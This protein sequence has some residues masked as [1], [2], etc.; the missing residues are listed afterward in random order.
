MKIL[1]TVVIISTALFPALESRHVKCDR[2]GG[3]CIDGGEETIKNMISSWDVRRRILQAA[4]YISYDA[5]NHNIPAKQ[6][7]ISYDALKHNV[8]AKQ[9]GQK[10][11]PDNQYRR[12]CLL[13]TL[14]LRIPN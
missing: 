2:F 12:A 8:P 5:I 7:Y 1:I 14:C 6:R 9:H 10:D 13:N 3:N 4:R 11:L